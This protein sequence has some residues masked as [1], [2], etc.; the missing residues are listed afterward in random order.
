[1]WDFIS[2]QNGTLFIKGG[3]L[4]DLYKQQLVQLEA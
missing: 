2:I 1:M 4:W 3:Y